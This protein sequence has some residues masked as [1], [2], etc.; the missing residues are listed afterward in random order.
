MED[1]KKLFK[2]FGKLKN[3]NTSLNRDG[4][5]LG[6]TICE[7]L[8]TQ[9][10]GKIQVQSGGLGQGTTFEFYFE[11]DYYQ[12]VGESSRRRARSEF[13]MA[14][15]YHHMDESQADKDLSDIQM[16]INQSNYLLTQSADQD[17]EEEKDDLPQN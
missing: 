17:Q 5:G 16:D 2:T 12:E 1:Q 10:G 14:A 9:N 4:I 6:L 7:A 3:N 8:V 11:L 13:N 15:D